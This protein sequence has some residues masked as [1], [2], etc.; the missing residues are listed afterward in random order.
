MRFALMLGFALMLEGCLKSCTILPV[1]LS[2]SSPVSATLS[3][4]EDSSAIFTATFQDPKGAAHIAEVTLSVL[5]DNVRPGSRSQWSANEC[6]VRYDIPTHAL[7]L[8]PNVG[9]TWGSHSI[10]AG[11][12]SSFGNSQCTV[13]AS[14]SSAQISGNTVTVHVQLKFKPGFAGVKQIYTASEDV[15]GDWN[16]SPQQF[17]SF[18]VASAATP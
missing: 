14:G 17:G 9:G 5:S 10:S 1:T 16:A 2:S 3:N 15:A 11:S 18:T 4:A 7:W 6:L 12:S 13:L 8:V